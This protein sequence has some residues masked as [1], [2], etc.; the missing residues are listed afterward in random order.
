MAYSKEQIIQNMKDAGCDDCCIQDFFYQYDN[1]NEKQWDKVL[2]VHRKGLL[3][4]LHEE[5]RKIDCLDYLT[6]QLRKK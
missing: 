5:Q 4:Q 6:F 2:A 1:G 3:N